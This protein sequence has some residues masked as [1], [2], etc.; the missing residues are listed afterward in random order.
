MKIHSNKLHAPLCG[1]FGSNSVNGARATLPSSEANLPQSETHSLPKAI[2]KQTLVR[3]GSEQKN[4][5]GFAPEFR[6]GMVGYEGEI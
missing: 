3:I 1:I 2:F 5:G 6:E 4:I